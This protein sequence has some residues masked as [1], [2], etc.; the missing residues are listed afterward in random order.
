MYEMYK[1]ARASY[2]Q[3]EEITLAKDNFEELSQDEATFIEHVLA[4]FAA[5][6]GIVNEN[7]NI[8]FSQEIEIQE[9]R[10]FFAFQ[11]AIEAVHNETYNILLDKYVTNPERKA[12]L[13]DSINTV[14]CIKKKADFAARYMSKGIPFRKRI[15]AYAFVEGL[16]FSGSFCAIYWLK[17]KNKLPG[18][19]FSNELISRDEGLHMEFSL[20]L[21]SH[22]KN[23]LSQEEAHEIAKEAVDCEKMFIIDSIPCKLLGMN[24]DLM[25]QYIEYVADQILKKGGYQELFHSKNPF[26]FME[27][28]SL[29]GKTNFF[30]KR[31]GNYAKSGVMVKTSNN[32]TF[33]E[34]F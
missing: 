31:V 27:Q 32:I 5:S 9:V 21:Y 34:E 7:L 33:D 2:W 24:S 15:W 10:S 17:T 4:F 25:S 16:L 8:N 3:P 1:K 20:M 29:E 22:L 23:K 19:C 30:E 18:L 11:E 12:K 28:I 6:D 13:Q 14:P 26:D